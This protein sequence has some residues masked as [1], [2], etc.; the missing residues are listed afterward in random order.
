MSV[1][2]ASFPRVCSANVLLMLGVPALI[3]AL[4]ALASAVGQQPATT[5]RV[6][7]PM[8]SP[9]LGPETVLFKELSEREG[10]YDPVPFD[11][12][13]H[14]QMAEMAGGCVTCHHQSPDENSIRTNGQAVN[15]SQ[16]DG[17]KQSD[18]AKHPACKTCHEPKRNDIRVPGLKGALH[19]QCLSCHKEWS[20]ENGCVACHSPRGSSKNP[21]PTVAEVMG[22]MHTPAAMPDVKVFKAHFSPADGANV[23]FRHKQ[24]VEKFGLRCVT[25]HQGTE[26][27]STCH[28]PATQ[29][30][31]VTKKL[32]LDRPWEDVHADCKGCHVR[33]QSKCNHCHF[34][35]EEPPP[36]P[37]DHAITGQLLDDAH[38]VLKCADCHGSRTDRVVLGAPVKQSPTCGGAACHVKEPAMAFP[39]K[40][41]G[42]TV[43]V[44][45]SLPRRPLIPEN[46]RPKPKP[47]GPVAPQTSQ[48]AVEEKV[49]ERR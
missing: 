48:K 33:E 45:K 46:L 19:Q 27:C 10:F 32:P 11:H 34:K 23:L 47:A 41:P 31:A 40:R 14:A 3:F 24:H 28:K 18:A 20:G 13:G 17:H 29:T 7:V 26:S 2:R 5:T 22:R 4:A 16:L 39:A 12:R 30:A 6:V 37:F 9:E 49:E 44:A 1:L 42:P 15:G 38:A 43:P 25:C 35:D 36:A 8:P 21:Q